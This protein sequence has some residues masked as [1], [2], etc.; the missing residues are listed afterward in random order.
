MVLIAI[1]FGYLAFENRICESPKLK[2]LPCRPFPLGYRPNHLHEALFCTYIFTN[3]KYCRTLRRQRL[4]M[5]WRLVELVERLGRPP[6]FSF[7][8][9]SRNDSLISFPLAFVQQNSDR[10]GLE[11]GLLSHGENEACEDESASGEGTLTRS[12]SL[13]SLYV[14]L[15]L[16][17]WT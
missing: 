8:V 2:A 12:Y 6:R 4:R 10:F 5:R 17:S 1:I 7:Y 16:K 14:F 3:Q 9:Q 11:E 15:S 13:S